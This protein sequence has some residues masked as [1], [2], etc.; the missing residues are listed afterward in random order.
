MK[1]V[2][3]AYCQ[4]VAAVGVSLDKNKAVGAK[5]RIVKWISA[6]VKDD[7][8]LVLRLD[9]MIDTGLISIPGRL[10]RTWFGSTCRCRSARFH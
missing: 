2:S 10:M 1:R 8:E 4:K 7:P 5:E 6:Q 9:E 3:S